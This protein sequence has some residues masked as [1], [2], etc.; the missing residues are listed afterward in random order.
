MAY[1]ILVADAARAKLFSMLRHDVPA[2][3]I[4]EKENP[5]GRA[6]AHDLF[7]DAPGRYSKGGKGGMLSAME[8]GKPVHV[9]EEELFAKEIAQHLHAASLRGEY[10]SLALIAPAKFL[11]ILRERLSKDVTGRLALAEAKDFS[12]LSDRDVQG[13]LAEI[14]VFPPA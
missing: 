13:R 2:S 11:G 7:T 12:G 3:V 10:K 6:K 8:N 14:V 9:V 5:A 1:W 4:W